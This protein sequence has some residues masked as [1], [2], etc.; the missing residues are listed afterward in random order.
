MMLSSLAF[1]FRLTAKFRP[2]MNAQP[3]QDGTVQQEDKDRRSEGDGKD[4]QRFTDVGH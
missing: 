3:G 2:E 4:H 1:R